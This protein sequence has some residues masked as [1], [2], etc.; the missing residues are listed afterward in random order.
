MNAAKK[1]LPIEKKPTEPQR[2]MLENVKA[3]RYAHHGFS[4]RSAGSVVT[5]LLEL[6]WLRHT[7]S[8]IGPAFY[9]TEEGEN[10]LGA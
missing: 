2:R 10:A 8:A 4:N 6:G 9:V 1:T 3:G 5:T 7:M